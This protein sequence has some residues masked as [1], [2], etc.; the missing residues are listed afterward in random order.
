M[1][2]TLAVAV[3]LAVAAQVGARAQDRAERKAEKGPLRVFVLVGQSNMQG[4][5]KIQHLEELVSDEATAGDYAH[6]R[7][8]G[9]WVELEDVWIKYWEKRGKLTVGYGSPADRIGP[10]LGFGHVVGASLKNQ[11]LIIKVAWGGQSLGRDFRPPSSGMPAEE[12][13]EEILA[14]TNANNRKRKRPEVTLDEVKATTTAAA[15]IPSTRS[16]SPSARRCWR[17]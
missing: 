7:K 5:G 10:E 2:R 16:A 4:K 8:G 11:V 12:K 9:V 17:W 3:A 1:R 14:R 13:L 6:L 15:P